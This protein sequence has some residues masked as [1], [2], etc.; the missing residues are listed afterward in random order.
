MGVEGI[1]LALIGT[2]AGVFFGLW[3]GEIGRR[4]TIENTIVHGTPVRYDA[5]VVQPEPD[6][7]QRALQLDDYERQAVAEF[8][9][10]TIERAK[11]MIRTIANEQGRRLSNDEIEE[12]AIRILEEGGVQ[13]T[14]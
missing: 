12:E 13:S 10:G 6:A 3:R 14:W 11:E 2:A 1:V 5:H 7:E 9:E 8:S 4:Q